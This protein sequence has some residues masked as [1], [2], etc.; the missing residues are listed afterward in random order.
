[1]HPDEQLSERRLLSPLF[2]VFPFWVPQA[3]TT[4]TLLVVAAFAFPYQIGHLKHSQT[5]SLGLV[6]FCIVSSGIRL[7]PLFL[8]LLL[9]SPLTVLLRLDPIGI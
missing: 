1:M 8:L 5:T 3:T 7:S 4:F 6:L 2:R 9:F